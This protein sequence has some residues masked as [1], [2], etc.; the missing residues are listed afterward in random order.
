MTRAFLVAAM[1]ASACGPSLEHRQSRERMARVTWESSLSLC[2]EE[3][4]LVAAG[5]QADGTGC[6]RS[7]EQRIAF[8]V[9]CQAARGDAAACELAAQG[10]EGGR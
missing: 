8:L 1:A 9:A 6:A 2:R 3:R 7:E 10:I 5:G 4:R